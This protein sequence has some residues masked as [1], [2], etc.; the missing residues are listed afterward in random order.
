MTQVDVSLTDYGLAAE[1]VYFSF[2]ISRSRSGASGF[3]LLFIAF[4]ISIGIAASLG[5]TVHGFFLDESSLGNRILWPFTLITIGIAALSGAHVGAALQFSS[6][7]ATYINRVA[8]AL[9]LAYVFVVLFIR[10]DFLVAI[11]DYLPSLV[12]MGVAFIL[13]YLKRKEPAFLMGFLGVCTMLFASAAQQR[14][15]EIDPRYFDHN[16]LYHLLQGI[17]LFLVFL[18]ARETIRS[19]ELII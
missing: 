2:L 14:K 17:A 12:F 6:S 8:L 18:A 15:I 13:T 10:R 1:C 3:P 11:V 7:T 9:F 5:G 19:E 4:F 16:A